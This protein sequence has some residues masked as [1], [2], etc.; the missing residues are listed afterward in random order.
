MDLAFFKDAGERALKTFAQ[1]LLSV[2]AVQGVTI[3][4]VNWAVALSVAA[5]ATLI[6]VLTSVVSYSAHGTASLVKH[7]PRHGR[8]EANE[9][10]SSVPP[11]E[12]VDA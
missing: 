2:L 9:E 3:T 12:D 11:E 10:H 6:S 7:E 5:T 1:S 4:S 8:H